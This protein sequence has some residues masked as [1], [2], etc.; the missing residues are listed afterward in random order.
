[1]PYYLMIPLMAVLN[2]ASGMAEWFPGRNIY[3]TTILT[4]LAT[5]FMTGSW[6]FGVLCFVSM[7]CYRLPGWYKLLDIGTTAGNPFVEFVLMSLRST[8]MG[9]PFLFM[10]P[11]PTMLGAVVVGGFLIGLGYLVARQVKPFKTT[12][13]PGFYAEL[14]AGAGLGA[15][16]WYAATVFA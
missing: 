8:W 12:K 10:E 11:T 16:Y 14:F 1:M 3:A 2:R 15:F 7:C 9:I 6:V 4:G 5:G 13:D